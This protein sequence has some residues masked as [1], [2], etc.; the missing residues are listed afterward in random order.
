M[1][2]FLLQN[3]PKATTGFLQGQLMPLVSCLVTCLFMHL[4]F[5]FT[6]ILTCIYF[7]FLVGPTK[8]GLVTLFPA[9]CYHLQNGDVGKINDFKGNKSR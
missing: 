3:L 5:Y 7:L 8:Q 4:A 2:Q 9:T 1:Y 6:C